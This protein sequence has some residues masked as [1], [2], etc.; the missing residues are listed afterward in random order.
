MSR[1]TAN[2]AFMRQMRAAGA[3]RDRRVEHDSER[4]RI[5]SDR[6]AKGQIDPDDP[7]AHLKA[8]AYVLRNTVL[9][10]ATLNLTGDRLWIGEAR[11]TNGNKHQ[12]GFGLRA[13]E[14]C[15]SAWEGEHEWDP[16]HPP[17]DVIISV[18]DWLEPV[19]R[20]S[21][22]VRRTGSV[23]LGQPSFW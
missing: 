15:V 7:D 9:Q 4:E 22:D 8:A 12:A 11:G 13:M 5:L 10:N 21:W 19:E 18:R 16:E 14:A 6:L 1:F 17:V 23:P 3:E 20:W 2:S